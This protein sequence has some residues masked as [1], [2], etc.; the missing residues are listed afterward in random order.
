[1]YGLW[2]TLYLECVIVLQAMEMYDDITEKAAFLTNY[3]MSIISARS[4]KSTSFA[5][6]LQSRLNLVSASILVIL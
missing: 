4:K 3:L 6:F 2:L 5:T 1:M